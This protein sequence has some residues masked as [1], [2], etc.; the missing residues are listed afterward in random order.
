[1]GVIVKKNLLQ[2]IDKTGLKQLQTGLY[3]VSLVRHFR[4]CVDRI[5]C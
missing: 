1:M 4:D 5:G 2:E 3:F